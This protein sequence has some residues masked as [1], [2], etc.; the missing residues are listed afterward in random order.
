MDV[1]KRTTEPSHNV[2]ADCEIIFPHFHINIAE[3]RVENSR[4]QSCKLLPGKNVQI[5]AA[6]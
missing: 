5:V 2:S 4:V 1:P 6:I 3:Q